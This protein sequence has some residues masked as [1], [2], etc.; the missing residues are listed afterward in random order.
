MKGCPEEAARTAD[1]DWPRTPEELLLRQELRDQLEKAILGLPA[2]FRLVLA[3]R[4]MEGLHTKE[5]A[6]IM[7]IS[8]QTARMRLHRARVH[9]RNA[10]DRYIHSMASRKEKD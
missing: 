4:D 10:L 6:H 3:L 9:V 7:G 5:V 8:E 2:H 1:R